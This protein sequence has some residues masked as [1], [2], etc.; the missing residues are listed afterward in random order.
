MFVFGYA[1][2]AEPSIRFY[3]PLGFFVGLAGGALIWAG[4]SYE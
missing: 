2:L 3:A 1:N 4:R